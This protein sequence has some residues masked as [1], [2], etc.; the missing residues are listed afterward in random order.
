MIMERAGSYENSLSLFHAARRRI[1]E[2]SNIQSFF[3]CFLRR[4]Y[5]L[6]ASHNILFI[7]HNCSLMGIKA[8]IV[9][10]SQT[11]QSTVE[12]KMHF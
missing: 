4:L 7:V 11:P 2:D 12:S 3:F 5:R 6:C 9:C 10:I 1:P 8:A